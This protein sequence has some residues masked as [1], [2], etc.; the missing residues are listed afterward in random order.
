M[1]LNTSSGAGAGAIDLKIAGSG[2]G[3]WSILGQLPSPAK[4]NNFFPSP[5]RFHIKTGILFH[6]GTRDKNVLGIKSTQGPL[7][8]LSDEQQWCF[9]E[10][11]NFKHFVVGF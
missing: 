4:E 11:S 1:N 7:H 6:F 5:T 9:C 10:G 3:A 8:V 2:A